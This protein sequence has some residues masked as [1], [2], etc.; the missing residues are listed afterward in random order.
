MVSGS[1]VCLRGCEDWLCWAVTELMSLTGG[2]KLLL[3][4]PDA[5]PGLCGCSKIRIYLIILESIGS[6]C[7]IRCKFHY[8]A[9]RS[10]SVG[11]L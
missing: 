11:S 4:E 2:E 3:W 7:W 9:E 6:Q 8:W 1:C 5:V 10:N